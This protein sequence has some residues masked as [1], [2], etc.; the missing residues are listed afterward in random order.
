MTGLYRCVQCACG[1]TDGRRSVG[2]SV[3]RADHDHSVC[4]RR[5]GCSAAHRCACLCWPLTNSPTLTSV[6]GTWSVSH[7]PLSLSSHWVERSLLASPRLLG[8]PLC[9]A[10][11]THRF[12]TRSICPSPVS[13]CRHDLLQVLLAMLFHSTDKTSRSVLMAKVRRRNVKWAILTTMNG[14]ALC[15]RCTVAALITC[16]HWPTNPRAADKLS[17]KRLL[18]LINRT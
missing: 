16:R 7:Q 12:R 13:C 5:C 10:A 14:C 17:V 8:G 2:M 11:L 9:K 3:V 15:W 18:T 4:W 6:N 1:R